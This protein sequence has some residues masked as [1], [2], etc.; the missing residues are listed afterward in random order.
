MPSPIETTIARYF[1]AT[2][3]SDRDAWV[4]CF[5][6]NGSTQDPSG[7]PP[8]VGHEAIGRFFDSIV[9]LFETVGLHEEHVFICGDKAGVKWTGRGLAKNGKTCT[10]EGIDVFECDATGRIVRLEAF[11]DP[12]KLMAQLG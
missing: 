8:H 4:A 11:W 2:R 5:A 3:T 9:G 7:T 12:S 1:T 6:P 10:F